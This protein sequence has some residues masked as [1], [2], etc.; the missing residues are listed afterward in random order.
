MKEEGRYLKAP[1]IGD[2]TAN[3][4]NL[5]MCVKYLLMDPPKDTKYGLLLPQIPVRRDWGI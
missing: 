4:V 3:M 5:L 1:G 2:D